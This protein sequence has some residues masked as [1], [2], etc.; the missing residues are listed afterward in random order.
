MNSTARDLPASGSLGTKKA[1]TPDARNSA[2]NSRFQWNPMPAKIRGMSES[3]REWLVCDGF[4]TQGLVTERIKY[5]DDGVDEDSHDQD[6]R[7][8][9]RH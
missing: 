7:V 8:P 3:K 1:R 2:H 4:L 5:C 6:V 9:R